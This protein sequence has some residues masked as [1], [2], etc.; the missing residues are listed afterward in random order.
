MAKVRE[1]PEPAQPRV[2]SSASRS[3]CRTTQTSRRNLRLRTLDLLVD[4]V[5]SRAAPLLN[6]NCAIVGTAQTRRV[7]P[8]YDMDWAAVTMPRKHSRSA[9][10]QDIDVVALADV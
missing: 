3:G 5:I 8:S 2:V 1:L 9:N 4:R 6:A 7:Q 10:A